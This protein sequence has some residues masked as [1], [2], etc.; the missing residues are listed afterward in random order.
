MAVP[1]ETRVVRPSAVRL[2]ILPFVILKEEATGLNRLKRASLSFARRLLTC[3]EDS[4]EPPL[5]PKLP[6]QRVPD[7]PEP[8]S[9]Y[10]W[11]RLRDMSAARPT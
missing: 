11:K 7:E 2:A 8:K 1:T 4:S 9:A 3:E 5:V 6:S 10:S